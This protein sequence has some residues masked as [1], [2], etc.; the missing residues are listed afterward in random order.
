MDQNAHLHYNCLFSRGTVIRVNINS[1]KNSHLK[2]IKDGR[3]MTD[4]Y[5]ITNSVQIVW[6]EGIFVSI[7]H[8]SIIHSFPMIFL[9]VRPDKQKW[10]LIHTLE[11]LNKQINSWKQKVING[12]LPQLLNEIPMFRGAP[13]SS[14]RWWVVST[15]SGICLTSMGWPTP[16]E[17]GY[18]G[19]QTT[20]P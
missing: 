17:P 1:A 12:Y 9:E 14:I 7:S 6:I 2:S 18:C 13:M 19:S 8:T 10:I 20:P 16:L 5:K 11:W 4:D 15:K 3:D